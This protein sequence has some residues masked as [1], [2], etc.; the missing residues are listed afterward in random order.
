[1]SVY[2]YTYMHLET[3]LFQNLC[4]TGHQRWLVNY[5]LV[6]QHNQTLLYHCVE[7]LKG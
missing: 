5:F 6:A 7:T 3:T 2:V 1:M 4:K